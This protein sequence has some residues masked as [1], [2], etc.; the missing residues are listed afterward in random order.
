MPLPTVSVIVPTY[1]RPQKLARC[2]A[3]LSHQTLPSSAFEVIVVDDAARGFELEPIAATAGPYR[4]ELLSQAHGGPAA[5]RNAGARRAR[6]RLLAFTDDDCEPAPDWLE[7]LERTMN[8]E[9]GTL[10]VGGRVVNA[11]SRDPFASASQALV[12]FLCEKQNGELWRARLLTSN[13]LCVPAEAF[14]DLGGFDTS[15][16]GAG[17]EDRELC[18]RWGHTHHRATFVPEAVVYHAHDLSL[19][20]F[21]RQH[22]G[23]G[24]GAALL[25]RR[26]DAQGYG[27][28]PLERASFYLEL[29]RYPLRGPGVSARYRTSLLFAVSQVANAAGYFDV[30]FR[31]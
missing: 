2:L 15:F 22:Y 7:V 11:L 29:L 27:P 6:G 24:R 5:A 23:Y 18:L 16:A 19:R 31:A 21:V 28:L 17:G 4:C 8:A 14:R 9:A 26:A 20:E 25:R 1:R 13:N 30:R 3:S 12:D 10:L